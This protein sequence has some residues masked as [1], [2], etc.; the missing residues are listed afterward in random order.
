MG[1]QLALE[2]S[3]NLASCR[4]GE[5][6]VDRDQDIGMQLVTDPTNL[7]IEYLYDAG[8]VLCRMADLVC[9]P[10]LN[11]IKSPRDHR[12]GRLPDDAKDHEGDEKADDRISY[13]VAEPD[14]GGA[15]H[16]R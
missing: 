15:E 2:C 14:P 16:H 12:P 1:L 9:D 5:V 11:A 6:L 10:W 3:G 7:R 4:N 13:G 8:D